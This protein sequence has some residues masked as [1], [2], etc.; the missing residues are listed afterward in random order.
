M[1]AISLI[2]IVQKNVKLL[3]PQSLGLQFS[4]CLQKW[5]ISIGHYEKIEKMAAISLISIVWKNFKLLTPQSLGLWFS[6]C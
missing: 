3:T 4:K 6:E 1:A 5:N 2:S